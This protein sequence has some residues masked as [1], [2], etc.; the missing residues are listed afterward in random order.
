MRS[1]SMWYLAA[2]MLVVGA[3]LELPIASAFTK[4]GSDMGSAGDCKFTFPDGKETCTKEQSKDEKGFG[5]QAKSQKGPGSYFVELSKGG[6]ADPTKAGAPTMPMHAN[7]ECMIPFTL[8][9]TKKTTGKC[10][11]DFSQDLSLLVEDGMKVADKQAAGTVHAD[12]EFIG[13]LKVEGGTDDTK[14]F[15]GPTTAPQKA[16]PES[17]KHLLEE[18]RDKKTLKAFVEVAAGN[19]LSGKVTVSGDLTST[20]KVE[21]KEAKIRIKVSAAPVTAVES[22][23]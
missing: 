20:F 12:W 14:K 16:D 1:F 13:T 7:I 18:T 15:N 21:S 17:D 9:A 5:T 2:G 19:K 3:A 22:D 23:P 11:A 6:E 8:D 4:P 10:R